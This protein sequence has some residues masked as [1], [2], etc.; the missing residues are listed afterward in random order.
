MHEVTGRTSVSMRRD[1]PNSADRGFTLVEMLISL[2][3]V[4]LIAAIAI[5]LVL[6]SINRTKQAR[7]VANIHTIATA[8]EARAVETKS[9]NAAGATATFTIPPSPVSLTDLTGILAPTYI[10]ELPSV[11]G[12]NH[13]L[14][15]ATDQPLSNS[16]PA[17]VYSIRSPG[18]NGTYESPTNTYAVGPTTNFDCDIIFSNGSFIVYPE[19]RQSQ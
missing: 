12:W 15:F 10:R 9:Y 19:G 2:A 13:P 1:S 4:A 16:V 11:D 6:N 3:I 7:T 8:W 18:R 14:D 5:P 17:I